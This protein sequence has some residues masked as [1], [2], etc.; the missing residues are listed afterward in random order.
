[1]E[2]LNQLNK[3]Q[4]E[5]V[6]AVE[7]PVMVM[8]GAGSG[9]TRVLTTRISYIIDE[10]G[11]PPSAILAVTFTNKA[12]NEMKKRIADMIEIDT[13]Y[14]WISTFHSFA[15]RLL[16]LEINNLPPY[17]DKFTIIDE[18][19]SLKIVKQIMK[20]EEIDDYKPKEIRNLISKS[21]NFTDFSIKDPELKNTFITINKLY[22]KYLLVNNLLD[23][24]DLIIKTI[25]LF[26]KN[27]RVLERYQNKFQY[28][29]VDEFQDTNTLQYNLMFMLSARYHNLFVVGDDFQSIYSFRGA[30]IE[31]INRFKKDFIEHKLILLEQNYR[32]TK[33]ILDLAN[34][35]IEK[36]PNQIKKVMYSNDKI[37]P[38]PFYYKAST[39]YDETMFV[40]DKIRDLVASGDDYKDIAILYRANYISRNFEDMLVRYKIPYTMY[41]GLSFFQ[42]K[43]IKDIIAYL[44]LMVNYNDDFSFRRIV[45]EPKRKIGPSMIEKLTLVAQAN[46]VSLLN[47]IPLFNNKSQAGVSLTNF[48]NTIIELNESI[49][50]VDL[51][52]LIEVIMKKTDYEE[53]LKADE[54]SYSDRM[55]NIKEL[56]TVLKETDE[57]YFGTNQEKLEALLSD[58]ALRTDNDDSK[59]DKGVILSTYHQVKGLEFKNVFMVAMEEEIFPSMNSVLDAEV[60]EERRICYVG[61]TRAKDRLYISHSLNRYLFGFQRS[62]AP[63]RFLKDMGDSLFENK[64][65]IKVE[66]K[67]NEEPKVEIQSSDNEYKTGDKVSHKVFGDGMVVSTSGSTITVAFKMPYGVK[68]LF[69]N[70]PAIRKL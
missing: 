59:K 7:G 69:A 32:S 29:L 30:K 18:E 5:A 37:G 54:D 6:L 28:I 22:E 41:G 10:L 33:Q 58:L 24:D 43:E 21:K 1:M 4:K 13:R 31:N 9:K 8:A 38:K 12:A 55:E 44:R 63:S 19:D 34:T 53:A 26:K 57:F 16:R 61:I 3:A 47:A 66:K 49:E 2:L 17:N 52:D 67:I 36:N 56:K 70:H 25:E 20:E 46:N 42:R 68:T 64:K 23:F 15:A 45:N 60:E 51:R 14:M 65:S 27:P 62:L 39:S 50:S 11:I 48:Y 40:V 35:V